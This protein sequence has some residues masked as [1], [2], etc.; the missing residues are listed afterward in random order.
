M[1]QDETTVRNGFRSAPASRAINANALLSDERFRR[2]LWRESKRSERSH[3]HLLLMLI[4]HGVPCEQPYRCQSLAQAAGAMGSAIRETDIVGWF[5]ANCVLG[6][7]FTEFGDSDV[8]LA[9]QVIKTKITK[10]LQRAFA[11]QH[12]LN[13][14]HLSLYSFPDQWLE[15]ERAPAPMGHEVREPNASVNELLVDNPTALRWPSRVAALCSP[16]Q[17]LRLD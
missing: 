3:K 10:L 2:V 8:I 15:D 12:L 4:D 6:V 1:R 9:T 13:K 16:G 17:R 5:D 11:A 7:I 14:F